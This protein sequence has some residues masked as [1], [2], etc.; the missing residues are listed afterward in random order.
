MTQEEANQYWAARDYKKWVVTL[1]AR[2]RL[3]R[4]IEIA[5]RR[6]VRPLPSTHDIHVG[7]R[8][9]AGAIECALK[10]APA[11]NDWSFESARLARPIDLGCV[12]VGAGPTC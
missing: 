9:R 4:V 8:T 1:R 2:K 11:T 5:G 6:V 3:S 7:A 12:R 10:N